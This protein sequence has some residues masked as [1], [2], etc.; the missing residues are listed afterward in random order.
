MHDNPRPTEH[1]QEEAVEGERQKDEED[2]RYPSPGN[3]DETDEGE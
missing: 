2:M 3:A 1:E